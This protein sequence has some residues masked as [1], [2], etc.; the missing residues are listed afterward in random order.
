MCIEFLDISHVS[1]I[2]NGKLVSSHFISR[3]LT[4]LKVIIIYIHIGIYLILF[5]LTES[6]YSHNSFSMGSPRFYGGTIIVSSA[7]NYYFL[8]IVILISST[9]PLFLFSPYVPGRTSRTTLHNSSE[10]DTVWILT[11]MGIWKC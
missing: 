10:T 8:L 7:N 11:L 2:V 5:Y 6:I 4:L 1:V 3:D 9:Y